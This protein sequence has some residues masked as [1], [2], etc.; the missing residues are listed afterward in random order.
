MESEAL[1]NC[2][3]SLPTDLPSYD[4][5]EGTR[6]AWEKVNA[7]MP[8]LVQGVKRYSV[9]VL[10]LGIRLRRGLV[11]PHTANL[12]PGKRPGMYCRGD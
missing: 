7:Y 10:G 5:C 12:P 8:S 3:F 2:G 4:S 11:T 1:H 6:Q 9:L